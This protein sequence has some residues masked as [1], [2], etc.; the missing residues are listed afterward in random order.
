MYPYT[1]RSVIRASTQPVSSVIFVT[2]DRVKGLTRLLVATCKEGVS[3]PTPHCTQL[4]I[5]L[6]VKW[7]GRGSGNRRV[8]QMFLRRWFNRATDKMAL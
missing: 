6:F 2:G 8:F 1:F 7:S 4:A 3:A 5:I